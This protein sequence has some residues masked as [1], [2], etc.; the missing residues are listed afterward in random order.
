MRKL[1]V[2]FALFILGGCV[3]HAPRSFN[4]DRNAEIKPMVVGN[5]TVAP[6]RAP[7]RFDNVCRAAGPITPPNGKSFEFYL[8]KALAEKL[9]EHNL[10]SETA[11]KIALFGELKVLVFSSTSNFSDAWWIGKIQVTSSNG[12]AI[13]LGDRYDFRTSFGASKACQETADAYLPAVDQIIEKLVASKGF[14][15]LLVN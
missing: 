14:K 7:V 6:F 10:S 15:Q 12:K 11:E 9:K 13:E 2:I 3:S 8:Q 1:V 5:I 4:V